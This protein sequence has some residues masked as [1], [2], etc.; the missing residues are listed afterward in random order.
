[1]VIML[2]HKIFLILLIKSVPDQV[3]SCAPQNRQVPSKTEAFTSVEF[4]LLAPWLPSFKRARA[5]IKRVRVASLGISVSR[6]GG[7][8]CAHAVSVGSAFRAV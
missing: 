6:A 1:M 3:V 5:R 8:A 2:M 4:A 7:A